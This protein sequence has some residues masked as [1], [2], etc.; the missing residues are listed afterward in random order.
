AVGDGAIDDDLARMNREVILQDVRALELLERRLGAETDPSEVSLKIDTGALA[1][2]R[3]V[4][5]L[6]EQAQAS[7][8]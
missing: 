1:A 8:T 5:R 7:M 6:A 2:R 3:M 4:A